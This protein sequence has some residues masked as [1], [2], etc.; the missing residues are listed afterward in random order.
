MTSRK[1]GL[2]FFKIPSGFY[3]W[4]ACLETQYNSPP[5]TTPETNVFAHMA[6]QVSLPLNFRLALVLPRNR[7]LKVFK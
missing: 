3:L 5:A 6:N 4:N 2:S 1:F 7:G